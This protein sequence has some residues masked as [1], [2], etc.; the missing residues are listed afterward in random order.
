MKRFPPLLE[1]FLASDCSSLSTKKTA[2]CDLILWIL[3]HLVRVLLSICGR[4]WML[5]LLDADFSKDRR[6]LWLLPGD[7]TERPEF[8]SSSANPKWLNSYRKTN[9][10][11]IGKRFFF[12]DRLFLYAFFK[13]FVETP[14]WNFWW[15]ITTRNFEE[16]RHGSLPPCGRA[17]LH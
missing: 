2:S 1:F 16:W 7:F 6:L 11:R 14:C 12:K 13:K 5:T 17:S 8:F 10:F 9:D 15:F 4:M 3:W